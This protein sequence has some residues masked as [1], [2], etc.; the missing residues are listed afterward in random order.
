M[1][2]QRVFTGRWTEKRHHSTFVCLSITF[3]KAV[4]CVCYGK[5]IFI[6]FIATMQFVEKQHNLTLKALILY[7]FGTETFTLMKKCQLMCKCN[8]LSYLHL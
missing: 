5:G 2:T 6:G 1:A 3:I 8:R 7:Q 4:L